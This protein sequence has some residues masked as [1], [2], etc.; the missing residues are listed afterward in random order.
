[1]GV[2]S[3]SMSPF[4]AARVRQMIQHTTITAAETAAR[5]ALAAATARDVEQIVAA[6]MKDVGLDA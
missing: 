2:R 3:L 1:M 6:A 4:L 5:D